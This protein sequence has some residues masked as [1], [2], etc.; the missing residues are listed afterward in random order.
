MS[1]PHLI[2][3]L[4]SEQPMSGY[5]LNKVFQ[6]TVQH[7]WATEQSQIYRALHRMTDDGWVRVEEIIQKDN[8]NK[9]VYHVTEQGHAELLRWVKTPLG[10]YRP[11]EAWVGQLF[12]NHIL[13]RE[14]VITLF[15]ARLTSLTTFLNTLEAIRASVDSLPEIDHRSEMYLRR[16][17]NLDYGI[18]MMRAELAWTQQQHRVLNQMFTPD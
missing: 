14:Q 11:H 4:L 13:P 17:L 16:M 2:L 7:F 15:E 12:F 6:N 3:G 5:D 10:E 8:P 18:T 9:K 1:L